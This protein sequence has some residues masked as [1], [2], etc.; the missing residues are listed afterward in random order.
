VKAAIDTSLIR[1]S[2]VKSLSQCPLEVNMRNRYI[3][4]YDISNDDRRSSVFRRLRGCGDHIQYSVF[5]CDL[6][7]SERLKMVAVLYPL[8]E[9]AEDQILLFDLGP[10]DGKAASCVNA[11]GRRYLAPERTVVVI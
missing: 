10:V 8:I 6:S 11:I 1:A 3:V 5:R 4:T 7:E 2:S 9:H